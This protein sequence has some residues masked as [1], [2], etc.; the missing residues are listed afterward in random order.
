MPFL[1]GFETPRFVQA[2]NP[3]PR[4]FRKAPTGPAKPGF[5]VPLGI[6]NANIAVNNIPLNNIRITPFPRLDLLPLPPLKLKSKQVQP[7]AKE[8]RKI[9]RTDLTDLTSIASVKNA[10]RKINLPEGQ[11]AEIE[12]DDDQIYELTI[13]FF[14]DVNALASYNDRR[15]PLEHC[16]IALTTSKK[17]NVAV[18]QN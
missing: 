4:L 1:L 16:N 5:N 18:F 6:G 15:R 14:V 10:R 2:E 8:G 3:K 12:S 17:G 7:I 9:I 11:V 13:N